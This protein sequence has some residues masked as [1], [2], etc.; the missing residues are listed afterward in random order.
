MQH[1][2]DDAAIRQ[3]LSELARLVTSPLMRMAK[4]CFINLWM[5]V[6][7]IRSSPTQLFSSAFHASFADFFCA[8]AAFI[9]FGTPRMIV[10]SAR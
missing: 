9:S 5:L 6:S 3:L 1:L 8:R 7:F 4:S 2:L 10:A